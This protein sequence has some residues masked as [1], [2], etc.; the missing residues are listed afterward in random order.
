M[1]NSQNEETTQKGY[2]QTRPIIMTLET[3]TRREGWHARS[4]TVLLVNRKII[5]SETTNTQSSSSP[6]GRAHR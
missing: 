5:L 1:G 6:N 4:I 3:P 2:K